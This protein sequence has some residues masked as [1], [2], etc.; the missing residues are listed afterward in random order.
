MLNML[1]VLALA[2]PAE[3][4]AQA[5][6]SGAG[7]LPLILAILVCANLAL[8]V[9][10]VFK[11]FRAVN[12]AREESRRADELASTVQAEW[13]IFNRTQSEQI[14]QKL[15]EVE[16]RAGTLEDRIQSKIGDVE[17]Q[18][19]DTRIEVER[20]EHYIREVFEVDLKNMFATF[21]TTVNGVLDEMKREL[22]RGVDRI[23]E[24]Q[25][26]IE[27]R[28]VVEGRLTEGRAM[29]QGLTG[30]DRAPRALD[31]SNSR[32]KESDSAHPQPPQTG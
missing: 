13:E 4:T 11:V 12:R 8:T 18:T 17:R 15:T 9:F 10:V 29:I 14:R 28:D 27:G 5:S 22:L 32:N 7:H 6:S 25:S 2:V 30:G 20:L 23:E 19:R 1:H 16:Q 24:I 31:Q 26:I 21:D 3:T